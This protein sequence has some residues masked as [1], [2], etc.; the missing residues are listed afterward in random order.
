MAISK[1][2]QLSVCFPAISMQYTSDF[3]IL[4]DN[5]PQTLLGSLVFGTEGKKNPACF[6]AL[7]TKDPLPPPLCCWPFP[8]F[9]FPEQWF[10]HL[11]NHW[12]SSNFLVLLFD[13][14]STKPSEVLIP[15]VHSLV[16]KSIVSIVTRRQAC[17]FLVFL[18]RHVLSRETV[19]KV[20]KPIKAKIWIFKHCP[21][22]NVGLTFTLAAHPVPLVA[23]LCHF[24]DQGFA[25]SALSFSR[26][27]AHALQQKNRCIDLQ[28][29]KKSKIKLWKQLINKHLKIN[30]NKETN[31]QLPSSSSAPESHDWPERAPLQMMV[32]QWMTTLSFFSESYVWLVS[33]H[34]NN[35]LAER[36][37]SG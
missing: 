29:K 12:P 11:N 31:K 37:T 25:L 32:K 9:K 27:D 2:R 26:D 36:L 34:A 20:D 7:A 18:V 4:Q 33:H 35:W 28:K 23:I 3:D 17:L 8:K 21:W 16:R 19:G 13:I 1:G 10:V 6:S 30:V 24:A 15:L 14:L 5:W 22:P